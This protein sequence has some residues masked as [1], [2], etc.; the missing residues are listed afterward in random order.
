MKRFTLLLIVLLYGN[1]L[2][3]EQDVISL[4]DSKISSFNN[5]GTKGLSDNREAEL[6]EL[7]YQSKQNDYY[8]GQV[9]SLLILCHDYLYQ[10]KRYHDVF[11]RAKDVEKLSLEAKDYKTTAI[12]NNYIGIALL[13]LGLLEEAKQNF[14]NSLSYSAKIP[15]EIIK[16]VV[17]FK[18]FRFLS[19]YYELSEQ[20]D[21]ST[22]YLNK[23]VQAFDKIPNTYFLK[24]KFAADIHLELAKH[25]I[26]VKNAKKAFYYLNEVKRNQY[27]DFI[28]AD[29]YFLNA[30]LDLLYNKRNSALDYLKK[31]ETL[32]ANINY[33]QLMIKIYDELAAFYEYKEPKEQIV[34]LKK[35]SVL[36]DSIREVNRAQINEINSYSRNNKEHLILDTAKYTYLVIIAF[37][38]LIAGLL[39]FFRKS[40]FKKETPIEKDNKAPSKVSLADLAQLA[41][42]NDPSFLNL[43]RKSFPAFEK[44]LLEINS[45]LK[46]MDVEVCIYI[47]LNFT[48]KQIAQLK[49]VSVR[50]V[51]GRKYRIRKALGIKP[52]ENMNVW[53]SEI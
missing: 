15:E 29:F 1:L 42:A 31:A 32:A 50:A 26:E 23:A 12:A 41:Y 20:K 16:N 10:R 45:S 47:K 33:N 22:I 36:K 3:Q 39:F 34:Y 21:S 48:T 17:F 37:I 18:N 35:S 27:S 19:R 5:F 30:K 25:F 24:R 8:K 53:M 46:P 4:I 43:F 11:I 6:I 28:K 38:V 49:N 44:K 13:E 7:Y 2:C 9:E 52:D 40:I 51:E 14:K